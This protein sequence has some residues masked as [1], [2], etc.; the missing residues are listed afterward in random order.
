MDLKQRAILHPLLRK[1]VLKHIRSATGM[2]TFRGSETVN[3]FEFLVH[4]TKGPVH[5][6]C[7]V[8]DSTEGRWAAISGQSAS[9]R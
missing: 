6:S 1:N 3:G 4:N 5:W 8:L 9:M 2:V 7:R